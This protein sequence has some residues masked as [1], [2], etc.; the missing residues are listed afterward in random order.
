[1]NILNPNGWFR[2]LVVFG[3]GFFAP[4]VVFATPIQNG[5]FDAALTGWS[6]DNHDGKSSPGT[7]VADQGQ[8]VFGEGDSAQV[9]LRQTFV[10]TKKNPTLSF[11]V[12][13]DTGL[14]TSATLIPD[15]FEAHLVLENGATVL[16]AWKEGATAFVHFEEGDKVHSGATTTIT[17]GLPGGTDGFLVQV[18]LTTVPNGAEVTLVLSLLGGDTDTGS[19]VRIDNVE[20]EQIQN[21][22]PIVVVT[23]DLA[24]PCGSVSPVVLTAENS[25]DPEGGPLTYLWEA[26][27]QLIGTEAAVQVIPPVGETIYSVTVADQWDD[28]ATGQVMVTMG[29]GD[30]GCQCTEG[31][32]GDINASG[33]VDVVDVQCSINT[34][35]WVLS[36]SQGPL[37]GCLAGTL[38]IA[39]LDCNGIVNVVDVNFEIFIT[40]GIPLSTTLD[41]DE[42]GCPDTCVV[43]PAR[44]E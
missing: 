41:T 11:E 42:D 5:S 40:L 23:K 19:V 18:D 32:L 1:M 17:Q 22:P 8:A 37:P 3:A 14:N 29:S 28:I 43:P 2:K 24:F 38:D 10:K 21:L 9:N 44:P 13:L 16:S 26:N 39:D 15:V 6:V 4:V 34:A 20:V 31:L 12:Y 30:V 33:K 7:V 25:S 27:G 36:G 35:L